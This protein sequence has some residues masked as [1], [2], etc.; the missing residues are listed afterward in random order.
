M[1]FGQEEGHAAPQGRQGVTE[2]AV[3]LPDEPFPRQ[4]PQ[5]V[6]HLPGG[7]VALGDV[8]GL[9]HAGA[10]AVVGEPPGDQG[11]EAEGGEQGDDPGLAELQASGG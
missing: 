5:V 8:E 1:E 3:G 7:V 2:L 9:G 6:A 4:A 10:Q 11:E